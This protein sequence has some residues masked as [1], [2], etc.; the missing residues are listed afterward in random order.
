MIS[1]HVAAKPLDEAKPWTFWY[2]MYGAVSKQG[3][4]ADL[5]GMHDVGLGGCYLM[6]IRGVNERPEY[7][8]KAQQL[9]A[10][11]W[12]MIDYAFQQADSL[13]LQM[14]IH[15]S[16]GFAL[17]GGPWIK[18]EESM[19][20]VV[21]T[22]SI[23][24]VSKTGRHSAQRSLILSRPSGYYE[25]IAC[26]AIPINYVS[27][28][29]KPKITLSENVVRNE[30][31]IYRADNPCWIQYEYDKPTTVRNITIVTSGTNIQGER[32]C[33]LASNDGKN[34]H[35]V[36]QLTQPRQGWQ[37]YLFD[38]VNYSLPTTTAKYFRFAWTPDGSEG[39]SEDLDAAKWKP[40][41]KL[42]DIILS[43]EP[44]LSNYL[45][46]SGA[47]WGIGEKN[48]SA[49]FS[50]NLCTEKNKIVQIKLHGDTVISK[51]PHGSWR[52]IRMGHASTGMTNAT[53]GGG[54]GLECDKFSPS[55]V[56][57]QVDNW[58]ALHKKR[59]HGDV[60]KF[61]H[62]DS[63]ECGSQNWGYH[64]AEEFKARRGYDLIPYLPVMAGI[65][66]E[67]AEK[68]EQVLYDI[69]LTINDLINEKFFKTVA[70]RA[71][72]FGVK[73]SSES[74]APTMVSDGM[75]H[76]KYVDLP[77][78]EFWLNSPTHDKPTDMLDAIHGGYLYGKNI[79]Q[80]E[81]LTEVRGVWDETPAMV[82]PLIDRNF[83][84]G[85]NRLFLHVNAHNPWLDRRPGMTLD[86]IGFFF[87]RDNTWY[88]EASDFVDYITR[89]QRLLQEG[90][91]VIDIPVY[92]GTEMPRRALTANEIMDK[93]Q[94]KPLF[95]KE[96]VEREILRRAN[97]GQPMEESPVGVSHAKNILR[98]D[99]FT[100]P[101]QGYK[102]FT[103]N[104][105]V[106]DF[107]IPAKDAD[108]P[109]GVDF[110]HRHSSDRDIYFLTN[111]SGKDLKFAASFRVRGKKAL[112]YDAVTDKT[113]LAGDFCEKDGRSFVSLS[114][115]K[116]AS[117]FVIFTNDIKG[118]S[119]K[120]QLTYS[121]PLNA[122]KWQV[123]FRDNKE[124]VETDTLFDWSK[125]DNTKIKY[126]SGHAVYTTTFKFKHGK[127][128]KVMLNL[129]EV[130]DIATVYVNG[131]NCGTAWTAPYEVDI[132]EA[133]KK[134]TNALRIV[135]VNT[136]AN[137]LLG[138]DINLPPFRGIWTNAKYR[139]KSQTPI[140]A[141]L[142][143]KI[144]LNY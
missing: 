135:V 65:A 73:L 7:G 69:R 102:Y 49:D 52:I 24:S 39:G 129:G 138:D 93:P 95:R 118:Y 66:I 112:L 37:S 141:G 113:Y 109:D 125:Y 70:E 8:G 96:Y 128:N 142:L 99:D 34:F 48:T 57:K 67:S 74:V 6:P 137:A 59:P 127:Q 81:G 18:P 3:I 44:L 10:T 23:V 103:T 117:L 114:L 35:K 28:T 106:N 110:A 50:K 91:P 132:T 131:I 139:R 89:C 100:N 38:K 90:K 101:L 120:E 31:G 53:A 116:D 134:G 20:H 15:I 126:Y 14:G 104:K 124:C 94:L 60:V 30:K 64:F 144:T 45:I 88:K 13:G 68:S 11:Y 80:A 41:L 51:L 5:Q 119:R 47:L 123:V 27:L 42:K 1:L 29:G 25:D 22:D 58:F 133:V 76:Y 122:Q 77:M 43:S 12:D 75:D 71:K 33:V 62:V 61:L 21:W 55:A 63:W 143:G 72:A 2:W 16:D 115:A 87:Q 84:L 140:S 85:I 111:Q 121:E 105:P 78:G 9:S 56:N 40:N 86:G 36:K 97:V 108:L 19:Q 130:K 32:I 4:H 82:K 79:I 92:N 107:T 136:W 54:K 26:Y 17:A 83:A 46:K 98:A